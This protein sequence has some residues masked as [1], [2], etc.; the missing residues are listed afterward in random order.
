[1]KNLLRIL[2]LSVALS[3]VSC[4]TFP[5]NLGTQ[6][7]DQIV[8]FDPKGTARETYN[9]RPG[10][11]RWN[12]ATSRVTFIDADTGQRVDRIASWEVTR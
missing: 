3:G 9:V 11:L 7:G 10:S 1:M 5:G 6:R 2:M 8:L 4:Q 12:Q